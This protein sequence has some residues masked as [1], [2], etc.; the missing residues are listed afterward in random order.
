[1]DQH[2]HQGAVPVV[3]DDHAVAAIDGT[4]QGK[5]LALFLPIFLDVIFYVYDRGC[6]MDTKWDMYNQLDM[7]WACPS[8]VRHLWENHIKFIGYLWY[9]LECIPLFLDIIWI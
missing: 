1:M 3:A 4:T 6:N 2:G 5:F 8:I 7:I 9:M